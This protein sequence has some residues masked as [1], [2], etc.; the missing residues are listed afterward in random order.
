MKNKKYTVSKTFC[1]LPWIHLSTRP[2]GHLRCCCTACAS[3]AGPVVTKPEVGYIKNPNGRPAN[4]NTCDLLTAWNNDYMKNIRLAMMHGDTPPS[5]EKCFKEE[6]AGFQSKRIWETRMWSERLDVK[7]L[8]S[9]TKEDGSVFPKISYVDLRMGSKCDLKCIMCSPHDSSEW[10]S[11]WY[12]L[13][14]KIESK[15]LKQIMM[16]NNKGRTDDGGYD[17]HK[18]NKQFWKQFYKQIPNLKQLY[19]AGGEPLIIDEHYD[20]LRECI[21]Q[22][23]AKNMELRYNSNGLN[24]PENLFELW[25]HFKKVKFGFSLDSVDKMNY[26]IRYP[27]DWKMIVKNLKRLDNTP[28][29]IEVTIACAVQILNIF[30]IPDF[31]KWKLGMNFKKINTWPMGAGLVNSHFVYHPAHL[32]VKVLPLWFKEKIRSKFEEFY[33]WLRDEHSS[34][35]EF[36]SHPY[37]IKRLKAMVDFVDSE[38]WSSLMP[39]F[40]EYIKKMDKIRGTKF[41]E[42]FPEMKDLLLK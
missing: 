29:N 24:L 19:F 11:D 28:D 12:K 36:I 9:D 5:C 10:I 18:N 14:P 41:K 33:V 13:Y 25:G 26:Y 30:Y 2:N 27:S 31:I 38:N 6:K 15:R 16:W 7:K 35:D 3:S 42:T 39:E 4:L 34:D 22:G 20:L 23:Y 21:K 40:R 8:I 1:I 37:G 17:W 32:N